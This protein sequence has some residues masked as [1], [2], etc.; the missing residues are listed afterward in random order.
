VATSA[1]AVKCSNLLPVSKAFG[2]KAKSRYCSP[3]SKEPNQRQAREVTKCLAIPYEVMTIEHWIF[4]V[5]RLVCYFTKKSG[6]H[7]QRSD[8]FF[9]ARTHKENYP[10]KLRDPFR[11]TFLS[12]F[13]CGA[14]KNSPRRR[15]KDL[16][17]R[18]ARNW[19][20]QWPP[21]KALRF[22]LHSWAVTIMQRKYY[23]R[24]K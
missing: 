16:K 7:L 13:V 18:A 6:N 23:P 3:K 1:G 20:S 24:L 22:G 19:I 2:G 12:S 10:L 5:L 8:G 14:K 15:Q 21:R 9:H 11:V 4:L 17:A